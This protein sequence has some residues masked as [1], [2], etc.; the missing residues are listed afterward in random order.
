LYN[1]YQFFS[2]LIIPYQKKLIIRNIRT[3]HDTNMDDNNMLSVIISSE[4]LI[5][6]IRS[7]PY[8]KSSPFIF[9]MKP[10]HAYILFGRKSN[11]NIYFYNLSNYPFIIKDARDT[12]RFNMSD[13]IESQSDHLI[14]DTCFYFNSEGKIEFDTFWIDKDCIHLSNTE[15]TFHKSHLIFLEGIDTN[16]LYKYSYKGISLLELETD[17]GLSNFLDYAHS[18][19]LKKTEM[20]MNSIVELGQRAISQHNKQ[21]KNS[22]PKSYIRYSILK[23]TYHNKSSSFHTFIIR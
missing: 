3:E 13:N 10:K 6:D 12:V 17:Y 16:T 19:Y 1:K 9:G 15:Q 14:I 11:K 23:S 2:A 18:A 7:G 20:W 21:F 5:D 4:F 22:I 8:T